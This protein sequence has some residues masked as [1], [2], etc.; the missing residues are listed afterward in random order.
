MKNNNKHPKAI[1][2]DADDKVMLININQKYRDSMSDKEILEVVRMSWVVGLRRD[3]V[4][5]VL[6]TYQGEVIGVFTII[7]WYP[8]KI[9]NNRQRWLFKGKVAP[10]NIQNKY[11]GGSIANYI[12]RGAQNPIR[13]INC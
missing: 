12:K 3:K 7:Q 1:T 5:Y 9:Q 6:A 11:I 8:D 10:S 4:N 13:Y 2:I